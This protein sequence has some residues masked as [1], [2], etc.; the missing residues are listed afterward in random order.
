M[1]FLSLV[2]LVGG[3]V[4]ETIYLTN[5]T[6]Q[7]HTIG[8]KVMVNFCKPDDMH[9]IHLKPAWE[10]ICENYAGHDDVFVGSVDCKR[11]G[12][13]LCEHFLIYAY[14]TI[15]HGDWDN[16]T[17]YHGAQ[18]SYI[19]HETSNGGH[20]GAI[21][22]FVESYLAPHCD[23]EHLDVCDDNERPKVEQYMRMTEE[24]LEVLYHETLDKVDVEIPL[25]KKVI[26]H[27]KHAP[28]E[29]DVKA[30]L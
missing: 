16:L 25:M 7:K 5:E 10:L 28:K 29:D 24:D 6:W 9:C 23:P 13:T 8:K 1:K 12:R 14:P 17:V 3:G 18:S 26:A 19:G 22:H 4:S 11:S 30:E 2:L 21:R 20:Y 27:H 15:V